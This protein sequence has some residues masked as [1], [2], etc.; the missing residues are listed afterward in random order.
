[1]RTVKNEDRKKEVEYLRMALNLC[2]INCGYETADLI[3]KAQV[4][5][6]QLGGDFKLS[7]GVDL[8]DRWKKYWDEYHK[9]VED[10]QQ[11]E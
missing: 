3:I 7:D 11:N 6:K 2:E 1:M 5:L 10:T 9:N 8:Y 4:K